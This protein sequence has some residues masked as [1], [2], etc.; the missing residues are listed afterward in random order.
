MV[1]VLSEDSF[2]DPPADVAAIGALSREAARRVG[3]PFVA[4]DIA[5]SRMFRRSGHRFA[6]KNMRQRKNR[7]PFPR[8]VLHG[9]DSA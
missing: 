1:V 9:R 2:V 6:D 7:Q 5:S 8:E 4:V 3:T